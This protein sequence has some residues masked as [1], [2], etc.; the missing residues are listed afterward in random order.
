MRPAPLAAL[1][2]EAT[3]LRAILGKSVAIA[4]GKARE[5][6][7]RPLAVAPAKQTKG[8]KRK[9]K[10]QRPQVNLEVD[11][12]PLLFGFWPLDFGLVRAA[13]GQVKETP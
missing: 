8:Q 1:I 9:A 2:D 7:G 6:D 4:R 11:L 5:R 12:R 13:Q 10:E 3:Q